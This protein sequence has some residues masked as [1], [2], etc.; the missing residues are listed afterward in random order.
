MGSWFAHCFSSSHIVLFNMT[1]G[2]SVASSAT[3]NN[4]SSSS[5]AS[6]LYKLKVTLFDDQCVDEEGR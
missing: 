1:T 6:L 3:E 2:F 5:S 4:L